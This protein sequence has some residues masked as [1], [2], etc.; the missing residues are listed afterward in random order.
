MANIE[1][2]VTIE[3]G[4]ALLREIAKRVCT[5]QHENKYGMPKSECEICKARELLKE[6]ESE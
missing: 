2:H 6:L 3:N 4:L 5:R 1:A